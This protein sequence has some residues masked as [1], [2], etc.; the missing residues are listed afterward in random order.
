[1]STR[2]I[3]SPAP[4]HAVPP[5]APTSLVSR[6]A[7]T[8]I[9]PTRAFEQLRDGPAP[10]VG[11]ALVAA[12]AAAAATLVQALLFSPH[13]LSQFLLQQMGDA[14]SRLDA[15][16]LAQLEA[17]A[18]VRFIIGAVATVPVAFIQVG[19]LG[20]VLAGVWGLVLGGR[21]QVR[22][23]VAVVAHAML[24][25]SLGLVVTTGFMAAAHQMGLSLSAA[26]LVPSLD[27]NGVAHKVLGAITPFGVWMVW[28]MAFGGAVVNR[29]KGWAGAFAL[30]FGLQMALV[31]GW[32]LLQHALFARA[33]SGS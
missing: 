3:E 25:G 4:A 17:G 30:L 11:A 14:A 28:L 12:L 8:F 2:F 18:R 7:D 13:E 29:R 5:P 32:A 23:Y 21:T 10:W 20:L 31:T 19:I 1:M 16:Q 9:A 15:G 24:V 33:A 22:P 6:I 26:L 27:P